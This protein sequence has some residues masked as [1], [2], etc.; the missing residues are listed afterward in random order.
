M[1]YDKDKNKDKVKEIQK[2]KKTKNILSKSFSYILVFISLIIIIFNVLVVVQTKVLKKNYANIFGYTMLEVKSGSMQNEIMIG[3]FIIVKILEDSSNK[4][5]KGNIDNKESINNLKKNIK[6]ND[7][8]TFLRENYLITHRVIEKNEDNLITKGDANN[9]ADESLYYNDVV[10][11]VIKIIPNIAIWKKVFS[12]K[13]VFIPLS[14]GILLLLI[15][16]MIDD[17]EETKKE[18]DGENKKKI[19]KGK[20]FKK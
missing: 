1:Q 8:I 17:S 6:V 4:D 19:Q 9:T 5:N 15:V 7:I 2:T 13:S 11:K 16:F 18:D 10:G 3:D 12:E 20:R 14:S